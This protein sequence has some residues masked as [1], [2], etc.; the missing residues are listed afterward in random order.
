MAR[1]IPTV[2]RAGSATTRLRLEK[3][4]AAFYEAEVVIVDD[5]HRRHILDSVEAM[6]SEPNQYE[7]WFYDYSVIKSHL[8]T[9]CICVR[10]MSRISTELKEIQSILDIRLYGTPWILEPSATGYENRI[11]TSLPNS[12]R[13]AWKGVL[14]PRHFLGVRLAVMTMS[15][16]S[17]SDTWSMSI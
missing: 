12:L 15:W 7:R 11:C 13:I 10:K 4:G 3:F 9:L 14:K 2:S 17:S 6:L 16:I 5:V 1:T 8:N